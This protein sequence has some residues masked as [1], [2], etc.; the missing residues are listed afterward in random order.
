M[1][2][3]NDKWADK[4]RALMAKAEDPATTEAERESINEKIVYLVAKFSI[5]DSMLKDAAKEAIEVISQRFATKNPYAVDKQLLLSAIARVFHSQ[6][7]RPSGVKEVIIVIGHKDDVE[8]IFMLY[9]SLVIQMINGLATAVKPT[10]VH[11]KSFNASWIKGYV[12]TVSQ[13]VRIAYARAQED[14]RNSTTGNGMELVLRSRDV[15]VNAKVHEEFPVLVNRTINRSFSN[16]AGYGA[17]S[18]AG[19][20]ADIGQNRV[21][22]SR[23]AISG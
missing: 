8:K 2:E 12:T 1:S 10:G 18:A 5:E 16:K 23:N 22:G 17:G 15:A 3:L 14:V 4:V 9:A 21:G 20:N 6:P 11:G 13:R 7:I 19:R